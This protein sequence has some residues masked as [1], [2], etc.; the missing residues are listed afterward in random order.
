[1]NKQVHDTIVRKCLKQSRD[2]AYTRGHGAGY[3]EA[4]DNARRQAAKQDK[5]AALNTTG[6][7]AVGEG[8]AHITNAATAAASVPPLTVPS[9]AVR[10]PLRL[11]GV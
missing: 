6:A 9:N 1:M 7:A 5:K 8:G 3:K 4:T 2:A 10:C 11:D